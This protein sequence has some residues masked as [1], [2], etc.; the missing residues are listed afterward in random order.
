MTNKLT[1]KRNTA[2]IV[3]IGALALLG[4]S[5]AA[6]QAAAAAHLPAGEASSDRPAAWAPATELEDS[7]NAPSLTTEPKTFESDSNSQLWLGYG[8]VGA[9]LLTLIFGLVAGLRRSRGTQETPEEITAPVRPAAVRRETH[10][11]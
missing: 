3:A 2:A 6:N 11:L 1:R 4:A 5:Y 8:L 9:G 10:A 7:N